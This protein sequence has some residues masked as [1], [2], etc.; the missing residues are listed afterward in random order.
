MKDKKYEEIISYDDKGRWH[1]Y[2]QRY[3]KYTDEPK[4]SVRGNWKNDS[5]IGYEEW[6]GYELTNFYIR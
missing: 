5:E 3:D 1:G 2:N 4:L 6:H